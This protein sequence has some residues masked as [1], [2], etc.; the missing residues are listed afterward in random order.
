MLAAREG[1]TIPIAGILD[2]MADSPPRDFRDRHTARRCLGCG[3]PFVSAG[4]G[5]RLCA[6]RNDD[7]PDAVDSERPA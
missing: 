2:D 5:N 4:A 3:R 1:I 6:A 7:A